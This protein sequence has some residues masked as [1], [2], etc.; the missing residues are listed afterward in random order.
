[1]TSAEED[2]LANC[3]RVSTIAVSDLIADLIFVDTDIF[4]SHPHAFVQLCLNVR[5]VWQTARGRSGAAGTR[6]VIANLVFEDAHIFV[7]RSHAFVQSRCGWQALRWCVSRP[8]A[9]S[10][11]ATLI[12]MSMDALRSHVRR[13]AS[14]DTSPGRRW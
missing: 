11:I 12:F 9:G 3:H 10:D 6:D 2:V 14:L 4:C 13:C 8:G 7:S 1:L 5:C